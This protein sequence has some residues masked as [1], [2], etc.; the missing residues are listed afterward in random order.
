MGISLVEGRDL[1]A[2]EGRIWMRSTRGRQQ[3]DVIYRRIDDDFLD[4]VAF[5]PES[6]LGVA[7]LVQ[8]LPGGARCCR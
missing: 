2:D 1:F 4:P 6:M 3:V 7:G 5:N 8:V